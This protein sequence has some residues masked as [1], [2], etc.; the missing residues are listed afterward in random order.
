MGGHDEREQTL[1]QLLAEMDG[2]DARAG[3]IIIAATNRPE[4]L[5]SALLRPGRFDRQVL[6]DRPDKRGRERI[7]EIHCPRGEARAGRGSHAP[8]PR[9]PRASPAPTWP[10]W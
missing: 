2:F 5:D 3:L 10:T 9:A 7:L 6:V 4:I 8:S 1:N